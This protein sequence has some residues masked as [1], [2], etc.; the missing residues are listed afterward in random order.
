M[1]GILL[2]VMGVARMGQ[3]I[4]FVPYPV[5]TGFTAGIALVIGTLQMKDFLGLK[6]GPLPDHY[7]ERVGALWAALDTASMTEISVGLMTLFL[8]IL[9]PKISRRVPALLAALGIVTVGVAVAQHVWP[10]LEVATIQTRFP[11][12]TGGGIPPGPPPFLWPW[13]WVGPDGS[14]PIISI[15][16]IESLVPGRFCHRFIGRH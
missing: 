11:S 7:I 9:W 3:V 13:R 6:P 2:V 12:A 14:A 8:L 10:G 15:R 1:A 4:E 16:Y 5:T